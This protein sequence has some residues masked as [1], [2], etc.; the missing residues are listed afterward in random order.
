MD[1]LPI[2]ESKM[3][4]AMNVLAKEAEGLDQEDP[5][6]AANLMRKLS[7]MTGLKL[8]PGMDEALQ[9]MEKGEDPEQLEAEMGDLLENEDP[10]ILPEKKGGQ[11]TSVQKK[12]FKDE[13]LYDL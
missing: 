4:Q 5:R 12:P 3:E 11:T 6:Q 13:T 2:D 8:G 10:F 7:D 1:D 9:R